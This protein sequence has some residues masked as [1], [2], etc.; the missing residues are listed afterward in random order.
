MTRRLPQ[1]DSPSWRPLAFAVLLLLPGC[2]QRPADLVLRNAAVYTMATPDRAEAIAVRDGKIVYVGDNAGADRLVGDSTE[3]IDLGGRMVLPG[4]RDTHVHPASGVGLGDC[5]FEDLETAQAIVDSV[6]VCAAATPAGEWVRGRGWALPIFPSANPDKALLDRVAPNNPVYL[7]AADGHSAWVNS[8]AL[9]V[10][11]ITRDT[12]DPVNGRIERDPRTGEPSG[13]LRETATDLVEKFLPAYSLEQRKAGLQ[14]ALAL[15][16]E[17][18]ITAVHDASAGPDMLEAYEA[19]DEEEGLTARAFVAQ[20]VDPEKDFSQV[21]SLLAW[22]KRW[23]GRHYYHPSAAKF[24]ADGVIESG[25]AALL[26]PYVGTTSTGVANFRQG[27]M[28]SLVTALDQAG[29]QIHIHAIG[30]RGIRMSLDALATARRTNG[31]HGARPIIAHIQ[32]FDPADIPRFKELGVAASFQPLW[33]YA[34]TYITDLTEPVLGPERSRWLYPIQSMVKTGAMVVGGSDWTVSSL[35]P[36][37]AIQVG[38]TRRSATDSA[39]PA[40]IPEEV[41]DLTAMLKAY[42]INAAYAGG[43]ERLAGSLEAGKA[44]DLIVLDRDLYR[45]PATEIHRARVLLTLLDGKSV[46]R[47]RELR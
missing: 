32:L 42:T 36:L 33:A 12:K 40:W 34:D 23:P 19:L 16:N 9:A 15:A 26:A 14:R 21:D 3:M 46:Y 37:D 7:T 22:R 10:A 11:G 24:F 5:H 1:S 35:N 43:E 13:T 4:F 29:I 39:G 6:K 20:Y 27:Q 38:V 45:I 44:A 28:D 41:T 25:T 30:D 8:K 18:G 47:S 2:R 31:D 17:F